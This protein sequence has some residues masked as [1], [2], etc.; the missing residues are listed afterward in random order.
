MRILLLL[1]FL[2]Y[3]LII[4]SKGLPIY[5]TNVEAV[6]KK[7][8]KNRKELEKSIT[9]FQHSNDP[10]KLKAIYFLISNMDIHYSR[11][12]FWADSASG[13]KIEFN[14]MDYPDMSSAVK[15]FD[16]IKA[17]SGKLKSVPYTYKDID[18]VTS[19]YLI[20]NVELAFKTWKNP[21]AEKLSF[22]D[23][24]EYVLPYRVSSEPIQNWRKTY[25]KRFS[26]ISDSAKNKKMN[27]L[28]IDVASEFK[29]WFINTWE[30]EKRTEPLPR[31]GPM[32]LLSRKKGNCDDI[33]DLEIYTLRSQG[34]PVSLECVPFWATSTG[35]HFFNRILDEQMRPVP[36]DISTASIKINNFSR[37]PSKVIRITYSKQPDALANKVAVS[38]IPEGYMRMLNYQ[39]VTREYWETSDISLKLFNTQ[40]KPEIA[41]ACVFNGMV[42]RPTWWGNIQ[43]GSVT[44]NNMCKGA[45]FLPMYYINGRLVPAGYPLASGYKH[46]LVLKADTLNKRSISIKQQD[47]YLI[48]RADKNYKLYYWNNGWKLSSQQRATN[49]CVEL[50]FSAVPKNA[51][52]LLL[53]EYSE[54]K[55]RPFIITDEGERL[56]W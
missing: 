8:G 20:T 49:G 3:P 13:K 28:L 24:C 26:W 18:T 31:L 54:G 45:V 47:K 17:K 32:Q 27:G 4:F 7:A 11:D 30:I 46:Q 6:L 40:L 5:P 1:Q 33:A 50:K 29:T 52:F 22:E 15:A 55:E 56:W 2:I 51:L 38:A 21:Y 42:W 35:K 53:P 34:F 10:L 23:F 41:Y 14:E 12:Y 36:F 19:A 25:E 39:D 48:F 16:D 9:Y 37:E 44:F 43:G